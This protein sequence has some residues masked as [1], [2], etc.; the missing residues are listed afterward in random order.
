MNMEVEGLKDS[1]GNDK[2]I[3]NYVVKEIASI[4]RKK[5]IKLIFAMNGDTQAIYAKKQ[6]SD[7]AM[8][9][10][11]MM[12]EIVTEQGAKFIDLHKA[13]ENDFKVHQKKFEFKTDGHWSPYG[14]KVATRPIYESVK[15][16][17]KDVIH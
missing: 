8:K 3:A 14:Q 11:A 16:I 4:A 9:L 10:N 6:G 12:K 1:F 7:V 2:I 15:T 13:F 5:N 17:L